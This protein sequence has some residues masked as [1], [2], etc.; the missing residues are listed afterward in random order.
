MLAPHAFSGPQVVTPR[1]V[2]SGGRLTGFGCRT[3]LSLRWQRCRRGRSSGFHQPFSPLQHFCYGFRFTAGGLKD[4][5]SGPPDLASVGH[6]GPPEVVREENFWAGYGSQ[7]NVS[8]TLAVKER[9]ERLQ[10][11][12]REIPQQ[13]NDRRFGGSRN[14]RAPP[15]ALLRSADPMGCLASPSP[16][17]PAA[18][19]PPLPLVALHLSASL[20]LLSQAVPHQG[21][22]P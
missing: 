13:V 19:P 7:E 20:A 5:V 8:R 15:S 10:K 16:P 17:P 3:S 14:P 6:L 18:R 11:V 21:R 9:V 4:R 22:P 1:T 12:H 2:L